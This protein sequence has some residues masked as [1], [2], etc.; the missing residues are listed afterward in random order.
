MTEKPFD[1]IVYGATSFA[2]QITLEYLVEVYG[3]DNVS[4]LGIIHDPVQADQAPA[5][6]HAAVAFLHDIAIAL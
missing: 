1:I 4:S 5:W 6:L 3:V 2:G